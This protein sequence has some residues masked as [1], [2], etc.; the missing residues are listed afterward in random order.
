YDSQFVQVPSSPQALHSFPT[1]RSSDLHPGNRNRDAW[2]FRGPLDWSAASTR[3]AHRGT[4]CHWMHRHDGRDD[5][6]LV[7]SDQQESLDELDRK[8]TRLNS[9]HL[10]ISYAVF[11]LK[12]KR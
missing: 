5:V 6:E 10:G 9:S 8:S 3:R 4:L 7:I 12:K 2:N 1:R 11:C